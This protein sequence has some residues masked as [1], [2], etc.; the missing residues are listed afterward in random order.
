M[1]Q[2]TQVTGPYKASPLT[3]RDD[4]AASGVFAQE[5]AGAGFAPAPWGGTTIQPTRGAHGIAPRRGIPAEVHFGRRGR[6]GEAADEIAGDGEVSGVAHDAIG[7]IGD[8][9]P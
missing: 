9:C 5:C 3:S 1:L 6:S 2:D 4:G 7:M 8:P